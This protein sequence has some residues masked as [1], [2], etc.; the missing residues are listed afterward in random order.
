MRHLA[1]MLSPFTA[2]LQEALS[3][4]T[5]S[6]VLKPLGW[7]IVL[8]IVASIGTFGSAPNWVGIMFSIFGGLT[9][10]CYLI[11][12]GYFAFKDPDALR[13]ETYSIQKLAIEKGFVG[14]SITGDVSLKNITPGAPRDSDRLISGGGEKE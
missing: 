13:S 14:D 12:Y 3:K 8:C 4:G 1:H 9:I 5:K 11:A 10:I 7:L 2:S 6:T